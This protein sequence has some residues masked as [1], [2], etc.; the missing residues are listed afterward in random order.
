MKENGGKAKIRREE[1]V[2]RMNEAEWEH[3][4]GRK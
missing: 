1:A 2:G 4:E 3:R